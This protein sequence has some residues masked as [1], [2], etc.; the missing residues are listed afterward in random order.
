MCDVISTAIKGALA[1]LLCWPCLAGAAEAACRSTEFEDVPMTV[2]EADP[3]RDDI[4]I[5]LKRPDGELVGTFERLRDLVDQQGQDLVFAMNAGMFH[6]DRSPVGH[7]RDDAGEAQRVITS[8]GP[9][10]FGMLPNGVF[11]LREGFAAVVESQAYASNPPE[12]IFATQ[13]G[14]LLV[15]DGELHPRFLPDSTSRFVRNGVGVTSDGR[16]VAVISDAPVNFHR[17][18]RFFRDELDAPNALYLD[19]KVSRLFAADLDRS[20]PGFPLGPMLGVVRP[21]D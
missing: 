14:P 7:Y 2:C 1:G 20:D 16:V 4:R 15:V 5:W 11:C 17:F 10:N 8:A 9:G 12:C 19:G 3:V 18:A 21:V 6:E 13:S